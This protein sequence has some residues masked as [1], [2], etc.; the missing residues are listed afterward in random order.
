MDD[1]RTFAATGVSIDTRTL[2]P[3]DLFVAL[4]GE[5]GDGHDF[6]ADALAKGAAGAMVHRDVPGRRSAA[7]GRRHACRP[8]SPRRL[9]TRALH[10]APRRGH[11]QCRQDHDQGDAADHPDG[12]RW[13]A[14]R[15]R[16]LQQPLGPAADAGANAAGR[17][18]L[19]CR[20]RHE[21]CRRDRAARTSR[22]AA[23]RGHHRGREG[24]C[25][26]SRLDRGDRRREGA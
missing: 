21:P 25:R 6:V 13:N 23:C 19:R 18:V 4:Q 16:F 24:A 3:G 20:D 15:G 7:A 14:C 5:A 8:A 22:A 11:R 17:R 1:G 2:Q 9:R 12:I 26:L 10:R